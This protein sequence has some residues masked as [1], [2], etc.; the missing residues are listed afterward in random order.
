MLVSLIFILLINS[1][2]SVSSTPYYSSSVLVVN[3]SNTEGPWIG[4][5]E[6]PFQSIY[7]ATG[8]SD[9]SVE[10]GSVS[11]RDG[12]GMSRLSTS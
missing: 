11:S 1:S 7:D 12:I 4:S 2:L 5:W 6:H 8:S 10:T 3:R 9:L